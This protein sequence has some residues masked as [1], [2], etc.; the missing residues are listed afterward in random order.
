MSRRAMTRIQNE[1]SWKDMEE[2]FVMCVGGDV[3]SVAVAQKLAYGSILGLHQVLTPSNLSM[4][5]A[6]FCHTMDGDSLRV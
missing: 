4:Q 5:I 1:N 6:I 2:D 3:R